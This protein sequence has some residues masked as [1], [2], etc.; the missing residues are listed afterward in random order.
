MK[1]T[2][3]NKISKILFASAISISASFS[4]AS[5]ALASEGLKFYGGVEALSQTN[6]F[7]SK[8]GIYELDGSGELTYG[9]RKFSANK[10]IPG[11]FVGI[12]DGKNSRFELSLSRAKQSA[13]ENIG[14]SSSSPFFHEKQNL[15][16]LH[17]LTSTALNLDYKPYVNIGNG[18]QVNA[19]VGLAYQKIKLR[20][21]NNFSYKSTG[22]WDDEDYLFNS[23]FF[24][25]G[26][27]KKTFGLFLYSSITFS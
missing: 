24:W 5:S 1:K 12:D 11:V 13:R 15:A 23:N 18:F 8:G 9:K 20:T 6:N 16:V 17:K 19:I 26:L 25:S 14:V 3:S 7:E 22:M 21:S 4:S 2:L 10:T 27:I